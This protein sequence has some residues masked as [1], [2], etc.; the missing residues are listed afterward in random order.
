MLHEAAISILYVGE[1]RGQ[2]RVR[3]SPMG[4]RRRAEAHQEGSECLQLCAY[5]SLCVHVWLCVYL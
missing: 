5:V 4:I 2:S 1:A 3:P